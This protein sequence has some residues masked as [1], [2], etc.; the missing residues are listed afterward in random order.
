MKR[1]LSLLCCLVL[2]LPL[3]SGD[4]LA[5]QTYAT[6]DAG[7]ALI[8]EYIEFHEFP[9]RNE[10]GYWYVGYGTRCDEGQYADGITAQ[11]A[12]ELLRR[13]V[14]QAENAVNTF[15]LKHS[16]QLQQ[17]Q[18]DALVSMTHALGTQWID[19]EYRFCAYLING[20]GNYSEAD[21]VN[22]I[23]TW[24]HRGSTMLD[25]LAQRRL[26]EAYLFLYGDYEKSA[27]EKYTYIHFNAN[28]GQMDHSTVFYPIG[29][30]YGA[31]P[32]LK[33]TGKVFAGWYTGDGVLV[34]GEEI[35]REAM[36]LSAR[37]IDDD[38]AAEEIDYSDWVNPYSDLSDNEW[39]FRYVR[40]LSAKGV[41]SGYP[42]GTFRA[43][44]QLK[45][46]EALKLILRAA[47]FEEQSPV[48]EHWASGYVVL[49][50]QL[51]CYGENEIVDP[52]LP[53][54]RLN[55]AWI[56]A[57]ALGL[58]ES[59][60]AS[61][62]ADVNDANLRT[63]YD[64]KILEG[65][66]VGSERLFYPDSSITRAEISAI[67]SRIENWRYEPS[68]D[69]TASGFVTYREQKIPVLNKVA[70]RGY[71]TSLFVLDKNTMV[72]HY[73]D[74][75]YTTALGI[76]VSSH[77]GEIDWKQVKKSGVE[78]VMIRLGFRGYGAEGKIVIDKYFKENLNGA[79]A[80]GL[81]VGVYFFSQA[82][83]IAEAEEEAAFV[84]ENLAGA[85]LDYPVVYDW[86]PVSDKSA[87][88]NGLGAEALTDCAIAFCDAV[89]Y[90]GYTPMIYYNL[91]VGYTR[92]DLSRLTAYDVWFAQYAE[93]P[94][95][96]YDY[97]IWQYTD[98]GRI[99]GIGTKVDM[100]IAFRPY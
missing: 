70:V 21:I 2:M 25:E 31:L 91:P 74:P 50:R 97:R 24:C 63:L 47:G 90:A 12:I 95:M 65:S 33:Q 64:E 84:I 56:T 42:D 83:T 15:L 67:V 9:Y 34:S 36:H 14:V 71:D 44:M 81:K 3:L 38:G 8:G 52:E 22:A 89:S 57:R 7:L 94:S 13:D 62:F 27:A 5:V 68:N 76:D 87:R 32:V 30:V 43:D 29:E 86:E 49:A 96:Y 59:G 69:P 77:Q 72:M 16:I 17:E 58:Q 37:W 61:P 19:P 54:D 10:R 20:I 100:N 93:Q 48:D 79:K 80:A 45:T 40:E 75:D 1:F 39:F 60:G 88:T 78:F 85:T 18:F 82:I 66:V 28:G 11:Q 23:G 73:H 35:A 46:G 98:S 6:S 51:G 55:V 53:I 92:Y 41:M 4:V 26:R 99:P